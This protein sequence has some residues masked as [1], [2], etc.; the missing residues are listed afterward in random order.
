MEAISLMEASCRMRGQILG[1]QH[2]G[3]K[4]ALDTLEEWR[5]RSSG[6]DF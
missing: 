5:T 4:R 6:T 3:T 1:D 2:P